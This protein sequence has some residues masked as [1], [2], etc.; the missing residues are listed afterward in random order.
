[1]ALPCL[2]F[3]LVSDEPLGETTPIGLAGACA[4][5]GHMAPP[6]VLGAL[7]P[8]AGAPVALIFV[9]DSLF[10]VTAVPLLMALAGHEGRCREASRGSPSRGAKRPLP[11]HA[12]RRGPRHAMRGPGGIATWDLPSPPGACCCPA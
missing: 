4:H 11:T 2:F 5:S 9:A 6:L 12:C 10:L 7:G 8:A 3:R 1:M